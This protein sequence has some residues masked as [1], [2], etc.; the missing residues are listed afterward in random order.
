MQRGFLIGAIGLLLTGLAKTSSAG[1][2]VYEVLNHPDGSQIGGGTV[3]GDGYILR[4]DVGGVN[5]FNA[6]NTSGVVF[7]FDP[8]TNTAMMSGQVTHNESGST[9]GFDA[10]DDIWQIDATFSGITLTDGESPSWFDGHSSTETFDDMIEELFN[11][12]NDPD[13]PDERSTDFSFDVARIYFEITTLTLTP[14]LN[15]GPPAY[16]GP[17]VWD[18]FPNSPEEKQFF[19]QYDWRLWDHPEHAIAGAGW[20]EV[21]GTGEPEGCCQDFLFKLGDKQDRER[22]PEPGSMALL[23]L[24]A[25]ALA[26]GR[27]RR[28]RRR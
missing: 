14:L 28:G 7:S 8:G 12:A 19:L 1:S 11:D 10:N 3:D 21:P 25:T 17:T 16:T 27:R 18:E 9:S 23:G 2:I 4:L 15:N 13:T 20:L 26:L 6:N 24:G 5:T 22:V